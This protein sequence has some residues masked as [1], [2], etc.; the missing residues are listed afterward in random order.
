M[1]FKFQWQIEK[2][3]PELGFVPGFNFT[4][5]LKMTFSSQIQKWNKQLVSKN[6]SKIWNL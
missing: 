5:P 3:W 1:L 2:F 4:S 6:Q